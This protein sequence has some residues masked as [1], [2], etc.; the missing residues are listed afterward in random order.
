MGRFLVRLA[1]GKRKEKDLV[2]ST[3]NCAAFNLSY[4]VPVWAIGALSFGAKNEP[5]VRGL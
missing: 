4:T 3:M 2:R 1:E 5:R